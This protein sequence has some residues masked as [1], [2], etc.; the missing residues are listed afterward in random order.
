M[1]VTR[2]VANVEASDPARAEKFYGEVLGLELLMDMDW[3]RT[4]GMSALTVW[5]D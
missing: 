1:K 2:I 4:D 5:W 3:I